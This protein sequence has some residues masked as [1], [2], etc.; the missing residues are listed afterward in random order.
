[1]KIG[2]ITAESWYKEHINF[3][4]PILDAYIKGIEDQL[5]RSIKDF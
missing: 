3:E 2:K 5:E 4:K 1:M